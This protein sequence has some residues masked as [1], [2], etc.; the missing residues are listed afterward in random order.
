MELVID[1]KSP[2]NYCKNKKAEHNQS[3]DSHCF[4]VLVKHIERRIKAIEILIE[5]KEFHVK[6]P[7]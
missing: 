6:V 7:D 5:A 2:G 1:E 4:E 3:I